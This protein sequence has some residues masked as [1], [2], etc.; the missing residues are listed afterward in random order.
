MSA[1]ITDVRQ[2]KNRIFRHVAADRRTQ[3]ANPQI[4]VRAKWPR[5]CKRV[6]HRFAPRHGHIFIS[7]GRAAGI[8]AVVKSDRIADTGMEVIRADKKTWRNHRRPEIVVILAIVARVTKSS[9]PGT[10]RP[11]PDHT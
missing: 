2:R 9:A 5:R 10:T 3:L 8:I 4:A 6:F 11:T 1:I 7:A